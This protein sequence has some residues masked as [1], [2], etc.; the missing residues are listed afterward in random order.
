MSDSFVTPWTVAHKAPLFMG[1][2][3]QEYRSGFPF[4]DS[5]DLPDPGVK[6]GSPALGRLF[7]F[8][9]LTTEPPRKPLV[10]YGKSKTSPEVQPHALIP[11]LWPGIIQKLPSHTGKTHFLKA[12]VPAPLPTCLSSDKVVKTIENWEALAHTWLWLWSHQLQPYIP[13]MQ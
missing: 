1:F 9:F 7:F 11:W 12:L 2:P 13:P 8:F 10:H 5:E 3:R 6:P 4:P